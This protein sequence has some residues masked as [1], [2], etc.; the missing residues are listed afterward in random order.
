MSRAGSGARRAL[1]RVAPAV[2]LFSWLCSGT[3]DGGDLA[4]LVL[5][6]DSCGCSGYIMYAGNRSWVGTGPTGINNTRRA[7]GDINGDGHL[8]RIDPEDGVLL[9]HG[10]GNFGIRSVQFVNAVG[11]FASSDLNS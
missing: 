11:L 8:D 9:G 2:T 4:S 5:F 7:F 6:D 3:A 1:R 10:D